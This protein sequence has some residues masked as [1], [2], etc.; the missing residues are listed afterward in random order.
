L[1]PVGCDVDG[2]RVFEHWSVRTSTAGCWD[3]F[4]TWFDKL[5]GELLSQVFPG[6]IDLWLDET[7]RSML[8]KVLYW[9]IGACARGV[10]IGVDV[11]IILAQTALELLAWN[12]CIVDR[13]MVSKAAFKRNGLVTS[14]KLRLLASVLDI[15]CEL[16]PTIAKLQPA[17]GKR[18]DDSMD[19]ITAIRNGLVHPD[20]QTQQTSRGYFEGW[21]LSLWLIDLVLLRL[22]KHTGGY[23]NRLTTRW[24]GAIEAVPWA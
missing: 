7:W 21:K 10:G 23:G 9:Y 18:W 16:S 8:P 19:A 3:G 1:L 24:V 20:A 5:H 6:F 15:P 11:G 2:N 22:C 13:K 12:Y 17:S 4:S 14:D